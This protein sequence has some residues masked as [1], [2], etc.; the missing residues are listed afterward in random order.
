MAERRDVDQIDRVP[1]VTRDLIDHLVR[2]TQMPP[3]VA[4]R[5]VDD[6]VVPAARSVASVLF[7]DG[8]RPEA[9]VPVPDCLRWGQEKHQRLLS[10]TLTE[11]A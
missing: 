2:S 1:D 9:D 4:R 11:V 10:T 5:V 7:A 8:R 3:G 6:V